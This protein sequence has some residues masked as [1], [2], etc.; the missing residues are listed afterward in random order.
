MNKLLETEEE[1]SGYDSF[2]SRAKTI[3]FGL[4]YGMK[5][6]LLAST[7]TQRG[8]ITTKEESAKLISDFFAALPKE[9]TGSRSATSTSSVW[10][11]MSR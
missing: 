2:R 8:I 7:L 4:G 11:T 5:A 9:V 1:K 6:G 3:N 10:P